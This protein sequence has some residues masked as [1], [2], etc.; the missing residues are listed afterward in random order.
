MLNYF[1]C[2]SPVEKCKRWRTTIVFLI[3]YLKL[4]SFLLES[5]LLFLCI[6]SSSV[7]LTELND[8]CSCNFCVRICAL[9][10]FSIHNCKTTSF[11]ATKP[12]CSLGFQMEPQK[13][14]TTIIQ[15]FSIW[16]LHGPWVVVNLQIIF[17]WVESPNTFQA[18]VIKRGLLSL[19]QMDLSV[20]NLKGAQGSRKKKKLRNTGLLWMCM[21]NLVS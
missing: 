12:A 13:S 16:T 10:S 18:F 15:S 20:I 19:I 17:Y 1:W 2:N 21:W 8:C 11:L 3:I 4:F 7:K 6:T 14:T 9:Y 5:F